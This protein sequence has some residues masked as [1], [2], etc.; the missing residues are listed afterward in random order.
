MRFIKT[1]ELNSYYIL[2]GDNDVFKKE[3]IDEVK[4][5]L[6][7]RINDMTTFN[8]DLT[9]KENSVT[10]TDIIE[11]ASTPSFFSSKNLIIIKEFH[12]LLK[13]DMGKLFL[14]LKEIPDFTN[15]IMMSSIDKNEFKK[16]VIDDVADEY[17][18]NFSNKNTFDTKLW[19]KEYLGSYQ[20]N[21]DEEIL[22]Y[23]IDESNADTSLIKNEID[24]ILLWVGDR[25]SIKKEDFNMLRGG[26]KEYNIWALTDAVGFKNEK[27]AFAILEKIFDDFEPEIILGSIF[28]TIKKIYMVRYYI[29]KNN[30]KKALEAVNYNSRALGA[31]KKQAANFLK[32]PFVEMLNIIMEADKK[33]KKSRSA[34]AEIA[35]YIMLQKIFL[36]LN[37]S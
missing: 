3:F 11:K 27:K 10:I 33:I 23:I 2:F 6:K 4:N 15:I 20:K 35:I 1:K 9:D 13:D 25:D 32:V 16:S 26:D 21:I 24:K 5:I 37:E 22:Q 8:F 18:F 28:Q 31:V 12:K 14:F 7:N 30:E 17:V 36:R 19:V 34:N 29:S